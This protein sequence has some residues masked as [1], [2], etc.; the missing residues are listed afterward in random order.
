MTSFIEPERIHGG[1]AGSASSA[2]SENQS[3]LAL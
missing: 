3:S 1:R 2:N